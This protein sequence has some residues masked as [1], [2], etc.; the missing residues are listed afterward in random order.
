MKVE[1]MLTRLTARQRNFYLHAYPN[2][3][4]LFRVLAAVRARRVTGFV[5]AE[6]IRLAAG[7]VA[8]EAIRPA[9]RFVATAV[10]D[11]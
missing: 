8:A 2:Y 7:F 11:I 3:Q 5:A 1:I 4:A 10:T 6:A 9:A